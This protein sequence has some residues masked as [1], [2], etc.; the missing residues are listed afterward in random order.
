MN[1]A[2]LEN[3][4]RQLGTAI[5]YKIMHGGENELPRIIKSDR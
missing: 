5:A 3:L 1:K 2:T 4:A